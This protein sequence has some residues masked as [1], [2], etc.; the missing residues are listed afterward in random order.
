M[1]YYH[2]IYEEFLESLF[3]IP[4][5]ILL[6]I[7]LLSFVFIKVD[8]LNNELLWNDMKYIPATILCDLYKEV[9]SSMNF[10]VYSHYFSKELREFKIGDVDIMHLHSLSNIDTMERV[11]LIR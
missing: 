10:A 1:G 11:G 9:M 6:P 4:H 8:K 3:L 5:W 2:I 7:K